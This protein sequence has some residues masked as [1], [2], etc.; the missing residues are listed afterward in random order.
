[1]DEL[2]Q[3][4]VSPEGCR[5]I[6][7]DRPPFGLSERPLQWEGEGPD[8]PYTVEVRAPARAPLVPSGAPPLFANSSS[9]AVVFFF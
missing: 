5:V 3:L 2:A 1:M 6:A 8:N 7:F 4:G 9:L